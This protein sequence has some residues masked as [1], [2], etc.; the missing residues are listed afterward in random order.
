MDLQ[1]LVDFYESL[2]RNPSR[3]Q[4]MKVAR[5]VLE[6]KQFRVPQQIHTT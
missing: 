2:T 5:N 4:I 3:L 6:H 1:K